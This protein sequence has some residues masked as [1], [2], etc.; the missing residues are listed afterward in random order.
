M[1][2]MNKNTKLLLILL[3]IAVGMVGMSYAFVPLYR[4]FC[5]AFGIAIPT[6]RVGEEGEYK[7]IT[8]ISD[9][10]VVVRFMG[11]SA[12]GMPVSLKP[13]HRKLRV[14]LGETVLTAYTA[15]NPSERQLDGIA[16]HTIEELGG[17]G[18]IDINSHITLQQCFCFEQQSYPAEKEVVLPLSF[19]VSPDL[20]EGVHTI[21]FGY[22]LFEDES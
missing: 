8:E 4:I 22:T 18:P 12:Q 5:Q 7:E 19:I 1:R 9:R 11:N 3:T 16:V 13:N 10:T 6:V 14:R 17:K 2:N 15:N 21:T 20:P